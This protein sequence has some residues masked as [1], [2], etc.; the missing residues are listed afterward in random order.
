[1]KEICF[2]NWNQ[3]NLSDIKNCLC[4]VLAFNGQLS[5]NM[6][7]VPQREEK[8]F[9]V[10]TGRTI[11]RGP[12]LKIKTKCQSWTKIFSLRRRW[13]SLWSTLHIWW[14]VGKKQIA[15]FPPRQTY[16]F[17]Q[18]TAFPLVHTFACLTFT[19]RV[20]CTTKVF[21]LNNFILHT[22]RKHVNEMP[23]YFQQLI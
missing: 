8:I 16:L 18:P 19:L 15:F 13:I 2:K 10:L 11:F 17:N 20:D 1:M 3:A 6:F 9:L 7:V 23:N 14:K 21:K 12:M 22:N 4:F 5:L